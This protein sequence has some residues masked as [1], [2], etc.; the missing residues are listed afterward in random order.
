MK[1]ADPHYDEAKIATLPCGRVLKKQ[2]GEYTV[3]FEDREYECLLR[4]RLRK[5]LVYPL[6]RQRRQAIEKVKSIDQVDPVAVGDIVRFSIV[7]ENKRK[8][9]I[10][11]VEE[12]AN[13]LSRRAPCPR[14]L[15]HVICSNID[16]LLLIFALRHPTPKVGL[17]DRI[18]VVAEWEDIP[19]E[20]VFNKIDIAK[21]EDIELMR[22]IYEP[23][24]VKMHFVSALTGDG[25][26]EIETLLKDKTTV[27]FGPSGVG[28]TALLNAIQP[29]LGLKVGEV[30]KATGKGR[31]TTTYIQ[32]FHLNFGGFVV[33]TPGIKQFELW[34]LDP[35]DLV[36]LFPEMV[37]YV[38]KCKF[39]LSCKHETEPG[40]AIKEAV[41]S[42]KVHKER[43]ESFLRIYKSLPKDEY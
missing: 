8:G 34:N 6:S 22:S 42:G 3:Y 13:Q 37:P 16:L 17:I 9:V 15:E 41:N 29:G 10:E 38:G 14:P 19:K 5:N 39:G 18:L 7:D 2:R 35:E 31:H 21:P 4:S 25:I 11:K 36:T 30:S 33:D 24:G 27:L 1:L 12:R 20:I 26:E 28:K 43:Y 23:S 32:A 40:C